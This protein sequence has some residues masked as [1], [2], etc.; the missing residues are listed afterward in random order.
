MSRDPLIFQLD[1]YLPH[2][3]AWWGKRTGKYWAVPVWEGAP[4]LMIEAADVG[5]LD[6]KMSEIE[7]G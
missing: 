2:W 5:E 7:R 1:A 3:Q 6:E 4:D